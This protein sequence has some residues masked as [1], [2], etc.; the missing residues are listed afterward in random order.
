M[1]ELAIFVIGSIIF[2]ITVY[3]SV[4]GG[5]VALGRLADS[6]TDADQDLAEGADAASTRSVESRR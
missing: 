2:A 6:E 3:G 5:G 1:S 4:I